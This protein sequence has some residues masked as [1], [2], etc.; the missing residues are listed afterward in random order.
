[1]VVLFGLVISSLLLSACDT[2]PEKIAGATT[3]PLATK[4]SVP[5]PT[6]DTKSQRLLKNTSDGVSLTTQIARRMLSTRNGKSI[7]VNGRKL[8]T[9][10]PTT[11][12]ILIEQAAIAAA[13]LFITRFTLIATLTSA[14]LA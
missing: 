10:K 9:Y 3:K 7:S 13:Y 5:Q 1:M 14:L 4:A 6:F 12:K 2:K 8:T 11:Y